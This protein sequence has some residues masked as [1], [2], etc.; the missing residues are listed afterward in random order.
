MDTTDH[1]DAF[2]I[3]DDY[4]DAP[5]LVGEAQAGTDLGVSSGARNTGDRGQRTW[6]ESI[7]LRERLSSARRRE[8]LAPSPFVERLGDLRPLVL[9]VVWVILIGISVGWV[10]RGIAERVNDGTG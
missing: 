10:M 1:G 9:L 4:P 8:Q 7:K 2:G 5:S 3:L 6:P